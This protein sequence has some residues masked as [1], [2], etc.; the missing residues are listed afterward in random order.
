IAKLEPALRAAA[1]LWSPSTGILDS[2]ALL[3]ALQGDLEAHGGQ[4]ALGSRL[5]RAELGSMH[6]RVVVDTDGAEY[7]IAARNLINTAGLCASAVA[8]SLYGLTSAHVPKMHYAKGN[9]FSLSG[10]R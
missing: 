4:V 7:V 10:S 3:G 2:H 6:H 9:Y 5:L 8:R 1:A